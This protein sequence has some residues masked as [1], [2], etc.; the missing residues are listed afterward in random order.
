M[1]LKNLVN[2][3]VIEMYCKITKLQWTTTIHFENGIQI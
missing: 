2:L 3:N 1:L